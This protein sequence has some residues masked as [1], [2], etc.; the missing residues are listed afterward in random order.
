[1]QPKISQARERPP[2]LCGNS[3]R[4]AMRMGPFGVFF[5]VS[6]EGVSK[7]REGTMKVESRVRDLV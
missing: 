7:E 3:I 6:G 2:R 4:E 5:E 1:M